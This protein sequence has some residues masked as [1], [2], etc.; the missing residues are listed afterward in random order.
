MLFETERAASLALDA[1]WQWPHFSIDELKCKC[2]GRFCQGSYWHD[3]DFLTAL[4]AVRAEI[5]RP[6]IITSG[7]R[8]DQWNALVGGVPLSR[9][10][11]IAVDISL[12]GHD[13]KLL[14][15]AAKRAGFTGLGLA[16]NFIHLDRR[17][18]P[19]T[20]FYKGSKTLW[21]T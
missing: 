2:A 17:N 5:K 7:H 4:E 15:E 14:L 8:C 19:A 16:R 13:R 21:Q 12:L 9:H 3:S 11:Q 20:W 18:K 1:N 10:R 6:L